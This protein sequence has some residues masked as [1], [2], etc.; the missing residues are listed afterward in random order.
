MPM[1]I[2]FFVNFLLTIQVRSAALNFAD[3]D[4]KFCWISLSDGLTG[5]FVKILR[6]GAR[7]LGEEARSANVRLTILSSSE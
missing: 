3:L 1:A 6:I 4:L 2:C 5:F 7:P